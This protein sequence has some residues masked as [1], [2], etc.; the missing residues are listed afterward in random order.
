MGATETSAVLVGPRRIEMQEFPVP[1]AGEDDGVLEVEV[2]GVCGSD[3]FHYNGANAPIIMGH[4]IVGRISDIGPGA[5]DA[6]GVGAG[7]RVVVETT[8]GCGRCERCR[9]GRYRMCNVSRGYGGAVKSDLAPHLWGGY[10]QYVYLPPTARVHRISEEL[11]GDVAVL[12][13]AVLGN[14]VRWLRT[15]GGVTIGDTA[16]VV[17]PGP[18][19]LA[20]TV[21]ARES[22]AREIVVVGLSRDEARLSMARRLGATRAIAADLDDPRAVVAEL[23][24][25]A[26][27]NV[28]IDVTNTADSPP[29]A[30][31]LVGMAGTLVLG[32]GAGQRP[33]PLM[34]DRITAEEITIR[35]V[36]THDSPAVKQALSIAESGRYPL[37]EV[38][39]HRFA[40]DEA[41]RAIQTV[42]G[43][44]PADGFIKAVLYPDS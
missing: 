35:G 44:V 42:A 12:V 3:V 24:D 27:A 25:G 7:D 28:V 37:D 20:A 13:C 8:F 32:G 22:G 19:G 34:T 1:R 16:V 39:S 9:M 29:L 41:E 26:M 18:Q 11:P 5:Q 40:V 4:E 33:S 10:G 15:I 38:V 30:L 6:W 23:T 17:G 36:N 14:G 2:A 31:D 21:A 43:E